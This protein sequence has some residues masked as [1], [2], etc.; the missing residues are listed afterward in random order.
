MAGEGGRLLAQPGFPL[1]DITELCALTPQ[2]VNVM[3]QEEGAV[4]G[5]GVDFSSAPPPSRSETCQPSGPSVSLSVQCE[6]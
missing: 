6:C 3:G 4:G 5:Q 1:G 2:C